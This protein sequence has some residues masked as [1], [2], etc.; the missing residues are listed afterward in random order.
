[1]ALQHGM[2]MRLLSAVALGAVLLGA[3]S[4]TRYQRVSGP[5]PIAQGT[6]AEFSAVV[7][8][9]TGSAHCEVRG[10]DL[11]GPGGRV[12]ALVHDEPAEQRITV[13]VD[14]EGVPTRYTD[15]R[16]DLATSDSQV[17]DRTTIGLYLAE[18]Y[19][20][21]ANR[22][23]GRELQVFEIPLEEATGSQNLGK[24]GEMLEHVLT[25]C[26]GA[27]RPSSRSSI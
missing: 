18:G 10:S 13:I 19:A 25:R 20:I 26:G 14:A 15:V 4:T 11:G 17:G 12:I 2:I 21:V 5:V 27:T 16:G 7:P 1:M 6:A 8:P 3:C 24:P 9:S 22:S 23:S